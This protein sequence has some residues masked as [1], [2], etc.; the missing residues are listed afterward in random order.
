LLPVVLLLATSVHGNDLHALWDDRCIDCHGHAGD[1][2]R[3]FFSVL[4]GDL[5]GPHRQGKELRTFLHHHY[6]PEAM[7]E[8]LYAMLLAQARRPPLY[9]INC[10]GCHGTAATF[11]RKNLEL[12]DGV[13]Y[14]RAV[15]RPMTEF[16]EHH[17]GLGSEERRIVVDSLTRLAQEETL[18]GGE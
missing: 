2:A 11:V 6:A 5:I 8:P 10:A 3:D 9:R 16:L 18:I 15:K 1:F 12:R 13:L 4:D 17:G 14:G 7:V